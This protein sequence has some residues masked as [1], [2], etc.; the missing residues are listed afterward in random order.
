MYY[1]QIVTKSPS[2]CVTFADK[3]DIQFDI[4]LLNKAELGTDMLHMQHIVYC[5]SISLHITSLNMHSPNM[6]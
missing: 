6:E 2:L 4:L 5:T 1:S 3:K